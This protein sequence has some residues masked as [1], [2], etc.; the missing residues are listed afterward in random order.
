MEISRKGPN[1]NT[2]EDFNI[3]KKNNKMSFHANL[4][5][6]NYLE[7][8][9]DIKGSRR[10]NYPNLNDEININT[11]LSRNRRKKCNITRTF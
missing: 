8:S 5:D 3:F 4:N 1:I 10:V 7:Y 11:K 9:E 6:K 2:N